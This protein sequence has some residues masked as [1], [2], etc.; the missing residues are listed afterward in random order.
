MSGSYSSSW[1]QGYGLSAIHFHRLTCL[2]NLRLVLEFICFV[3]RR[4]HCVCSCFCC[5]TLLSLFT[6]P[7]VISKAFSLII[8]SQGN[9]GIIPLLFFISHKR[10]C[11][12]TV[13]LMGNLPVLVGFFYQRTCNWNKLPWFQIA[14]SLKSLTQSH[15]ILPIYAYPCCCCVLCLKI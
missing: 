6:S 14:S 1:I 11:W 8:W 15:R 5:T 3:F 4:G 10:V 12:S 7:L 2:S 9:S 13:K